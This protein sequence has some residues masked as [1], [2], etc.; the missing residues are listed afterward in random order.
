MTWLMWSVNPGAVGCGAS[1]VELR[2]STDGVTWRPPVSGG[3]SWHL[4]WE[5]LSVDAFL[6]RV[7]APFDLA[8]RV[9]NGEKPSSPELTNETA[10]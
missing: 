10:P 9:G 3:Y 4:A 7:R 2:R 5:Q 6:A 1:T 8:A